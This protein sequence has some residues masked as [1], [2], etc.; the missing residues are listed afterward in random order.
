[1]HED[2]PSS[3]CLDC[4]HASDCATH[5]EPAYPA[6]ACNCGKVSH[7]KP[8][9]GDLRVVYIPQVP[10]E[11]YALDIPRR[12]GTRRAAYLEQATFVLD[13]IIG[14]SI[15]EFEN[16]IKPDYSD[17]AAILR[18]EDGEWSDV[19]EEEYESYHAE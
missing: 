8:T 3:N 5:N 4:G 15:F 18:Y 13:A 1:M 17:Y 6:T 12:A 16:N 11:G 7:A 14:L 9:E 19:D 2:H 10:M